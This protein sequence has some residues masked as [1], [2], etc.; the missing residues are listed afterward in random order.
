MPSLA[1]FQFHQLF[2]TNHLLIHLGAKVQAVQSR[3]IPVS[4]LTDLTLP[5]LWTALVR[6]IVEVLAT[7]VKF[8]VLPNVPSG[9]LDLAVLGTTPDIA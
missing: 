6:Y 4:V 8:Q 1:F 9:T 2:A 7:T 5:G 3:P